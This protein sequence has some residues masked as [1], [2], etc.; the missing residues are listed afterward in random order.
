[1]E[2]KI[3]HQEKSKSPPSRKTS[4]S[5]VIVEIETS[6]V[7]LEDLKA[8]KCRPN[9]K[10]PEKNANISA[11]VAESKNSTFEKDPQTY[12]YEKTIEV[13]RKRTTTVEKSDELSKTFDEHECKYKPKTIAQ[14]TL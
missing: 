14:S 7:P 9:S 10:K 8:E 13:L 11:A 4:P 5:V 6:A 3:R 12:S 1:M 2:D